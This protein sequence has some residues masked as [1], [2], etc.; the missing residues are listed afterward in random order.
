MRD[1][2]TVASDTLMFQPM[3]ALANMLRKRS[4]RVVDRW[5]K[6]VRNTLPNADAL[7]SQQVRDSIPTILEQ[8]ANAIEAGEPAPTEELAEITKVHGEARF[9][10]SYNV[11]ELILEYRLLR[12]TLIEEIDSAFKRPVSAQ[13]WIALD[14]AVDL[15]LQQA[16]L[17][18]LQH[19]GVRLKTATEGEAKFLA[20]LTHE[21][22]GGL[23]SVML[24]MQWVEHALESRREFSEEREALIAA[25]KSA[26][27]TITSLERLLQAERL[28]QK[29]ARPV[30]A[31]ISLKTVAEKVAAQCRIAAK[32]KGIA[33][34]IQIADDAIV[35][36]DEGL[37]TL[38]V[39]NQLGNAVKYSDER[40]SRRSCKRDGKESWSLHVVDQGRGIAP[41]LVSRLFDSF[42]RGESPNDSGLGLFIAWQA[43]D[44]L[45]ARISVDTKVDE[46]STF[47]LLLPSAAPASARQN[48]RL[49][50]RHGSRP[51]RATSRRRIAHR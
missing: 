45:G 18:F 13:E 51:T 36:T 5:D 34:R 35:N 40:Q 38:I 44:T 19:Q 25:R 41:E 26:S 20:F 10:E 7:T 32:R 12:K 17:A 33:I 9:H 29:S 8:M 16:V 30:Y 37:L 24:T 11:K 3:P 2:E 28:R 23:N 48:S 49:R 42:A 43:A 1:A 39:Q 21:I 50:L 31:A 27:E 15:A 6:L 4:A 22:R 14:I 47:S 46:G